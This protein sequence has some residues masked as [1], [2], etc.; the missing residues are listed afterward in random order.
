MDKRKRTAWFPASVK[1][2]RQGV[3]EVRQVLPYGARFTDVQV[4]RFTGNGWAGLAG[5]YCDFVTLIGDR[6]RGLAEDPKA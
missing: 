2:V 4:R 1:P 6:W 5:G 3:Y